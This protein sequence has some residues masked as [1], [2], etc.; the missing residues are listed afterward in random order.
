VCAAASHRP[1][2]RGDSVLWLASRILTGRCELT[3][4]DPDAVLAEVEQRI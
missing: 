3:G 2:D 1:E 4:E